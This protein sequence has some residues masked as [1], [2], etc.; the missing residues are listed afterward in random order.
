MSRI[1]RDQEDRAY[2]RKRL[3]FQGI[4]LMTP[5]DG[6][7][8]SLTD[9]IRAV[10]DSQY[11]EDLKGWIRRSMTDLIRQ[12]RSAGGRAYA[13]RPVPGPNGKKDK[14]GYLEIVPEEAA[15]VMRVF[16]DYAKG[17]SPKAICKR[18]NAEFM[19]PP[20]GKLW[21]PSALHG[22]AQRGTGLLRNPIY[23]GSIVWN[24]VHMVKDPDTGKRLSRPN[25]E[26]EWH[27]TE[28][29]E[30]RI[31][32]NELFEAVQTQMAERSHR[33]RAD[34][35][36]KQRRPKYLLSGLLKCPACG[37]GMSRMGP[38]RSGRV[39]LRCSGHTNSG[40]CPNPQ[41]F[42]VDEVE[43]LVIDSLAKELATP[44]AIHAYAERYIKARIEQDAQENHRR[45][46]IKGRIAAIAKDNDRLLD[47][48]VRGI[49]EQDAIDQRMKAQAR[50][51]DQL[52]EELASLPVGNNVVLHPTAIK[53]L[54]ETL[55]TRSKDRL[56][57]RRAKLEATIAM[58]DDMGELAPIV[59]ELIRTITLYRDE[60][61]RLVIEVEAS[62]APFLRQ[63]GYPPPLGTGDGNVGSGG[64]LR[65]IPPRR[66]AGVF[67]A[68][69]RHAGRPQCL[70]FR[71]R[72]LYVCV[73][74]HFTIFLGEGAN[75]GVG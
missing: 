6:V 33:N 39:R 2:I 71:G 55:M 35:I 52:K 15:I 3:N 23:V 60:D 42:Y 49:G 56:R 18:L 64:A 1:G 27:A 22:S 43:E 16:E 30:L 50:E 69:A 40:A 26:S 13:Y 54:A 68:A 21:S 66:I 37:S 44:E 53:H 32:P 4:T 10:I 57:T 17:V 62:L 34:N 12:G 45:V 7:V 5:S 28:V 24:K 20:R 75:I 59:R 11:L 72:V 41:T 74:H 31:V 58:L 73:N 25:P 46:E 48:L 8:T 38:D 19:K 70:G 65:A 61:G 47:L 67:A 63:D 36:V 51:R 9:G 29:P 14:N